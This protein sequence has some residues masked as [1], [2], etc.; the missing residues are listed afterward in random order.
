MP[1]KGYAPRMICGMPEGTPFVRLRSKGRPVVYYA[2][3]A[4]GFLHELARPIPYDKEEV[5]RKAG[6]V[7]GKRDDEIRRGR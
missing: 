2:G 6:E 5:R 3:S 7:I 1:P 4:A